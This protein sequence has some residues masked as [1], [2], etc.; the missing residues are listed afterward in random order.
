MQ[1]N[2]AAAAI[3]TMAFA[4]A[5]AARADQWPVSLTSSHSDVKFDI[6]DVNSGGYLATD[7]NISNG[8]TVQAQVKMDS[9][10]PGTHIRWQAKLND[11][12]WY[13]EVCS[14]HPGDFQ[15]LDSLRP[16]DSRPAGYC[17]IEGQFPG[18]N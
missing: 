3:V 15:R 2:V 18:C 14:T 12:C 17:P 4:G 1:G 8:L 10:V 16:D 13:G 11:R 5:G 6:Y 9:A 7:Q